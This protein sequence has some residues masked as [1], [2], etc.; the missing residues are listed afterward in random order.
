MTT[1]IQH[2][3]N[4]YLVVLQIVL[5]NTHLARHDMPIYVESWYT[6]SA[7]KAQPKILFLKDESNI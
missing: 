1:I 3:Y 5:L 7:I 4:T 2:Q 6:N